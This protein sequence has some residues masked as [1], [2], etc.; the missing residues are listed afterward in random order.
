MVTITG[1][2]RKHLSTPMERFFLKS[3]PGKVIL[4]ILSPAILPFY[5]IKKTYDGM[6]FCFTP[7]LDDDVDDEFAQIFAAYESTSRDDD[8]NHIKE[9]QIEQNAKD[10]SKL[11]AQQSD[12][13][14]TI[15]QVA[16]TD[17]LICDIRNV[18]EDQIETRQSIHQFNAT[19]AN[20]PLP[21]SQK[22]LDDWRQVQCSNDT[23]DKQHEHRARFYGEKRN[24]L[25][26]KHYGLFLIVDEVKAKVSYRGQATNAIRLSTRDMVNNA[27]KTR[28]WRIKDIAA[29]IDLA[30]EMVLT[31]TRAEISAMMVQHSAASRIRN[32][33][34]MELRGGTQRC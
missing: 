5:M 15:D 27:M 12:L 16:K 14:S 26:R 8:A 19:V 9:V 28:S 30:V 20:P 11:I 29:W 7:T 18:P 4:A 6:V 34:Y 31:P 17:K 33:E 3:A 1:N 21:A 10:R 25:K 2:Q 32:V 22:S 23:M 24:R 13:V